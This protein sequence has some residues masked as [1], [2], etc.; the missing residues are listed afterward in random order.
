M[1]ALG[2]SIT[3]VTIIASL[4][5]AMVL[6]GVSTIFVAVLLV[7]L[8]LCVTVDV[9]VTRRRIQR[10]AAAR[11]GEDIGAFARAF[12]RQSD[13]FDPRVVR[14]V[15]EALVPYV[16]CDGRRVPLRP[17]DRISEDLH[18]DVDDIDMGI[19]QEVAERAGRSLENV[20]A[21]PRY[22]HVKT[23]GDLVRLVSSQP[24]RCAG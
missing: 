21:N 18:I 19:V 13:P 8:A 6:A 11:A 10:L 2:S 17:T 20:E 7:L 23:V 14:A 16:E 22:G 9:V 12:D 15:W 5:I 3:A 4:V 24:P 1:S